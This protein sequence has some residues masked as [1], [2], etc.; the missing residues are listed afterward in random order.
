MGLREAD[1]AESPSLKCHRR[2][3][4]AVVSAVL[5]IVA[6]DM[7]IGRAFRVGAPFVLPMVM[8]WQSDHLAHW[9][10][11]A[12]GHWLSAMTADKW[13]RRLGWVILVLLSAN[14]L[15]EVWAHH[16]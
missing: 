10:I 15:V 8:I 7:G 12:S 13:L 4:V 9:A 6:Y 14:T 3:S 16:R 11:Q 2:I 5:M 1:Y